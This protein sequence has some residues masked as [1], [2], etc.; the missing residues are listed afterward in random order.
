LREE[1]NLG[2]ASLVRLDGV[3]PGQTMRRLG[4]VLM[5]LYVHALT[6]RPWRY[7][8]FAIVATWLAFLTIYT[9]R[10]P[11]VALTG[12]NSAV[13]VN[14]YTL[15]WEWIDVGQSALFIEGNPWFQV[16]GGAGLSNGSL[17]DQNAAR[18]TPALVVSILGV[19]FRSAWLACLFATW[20]AWLLTW[21]VIDRLTTCVVGDEASSPSS[22]DLRTARAVSAILV[23]TSPGFLAFVGNIDI[24][25]FG[26]LSAPIGLLAMH[27]T[28]ARIGVIKSY[29]T[30]TPKQFTPRFGVLISL[31]L[32]LVDG[33][34]QLGIPLLASLILTMIA[35]R[36]WKS[37]RGQ[38]TAVS[39]IFGGYASL[40]AV[41]AVI[42][43][44][45]SGG[46]LSVH[47]E[48]R[49]RFLSALSNP[50][51]EWFQIVGQA[52]LTVQTI[53]DVYTPVHVIMGISGLL[54]CRKRG[55]SL[56]LIYILVIM[57]AVNF[58]RLHPRTMYLTFPGIYIG[59]ASWAVLLSRF[60][61]RWMPA[62]VN[63]GLAIMVGC[64][65]LIIDSMKF[66][67][68]NLQTSLIW[69][70]KT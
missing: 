2:S 11:W 58:T 21:Y 59:I 20:V 3:L 30:I 14:G 41:W 12:G 26:Y 13:T 7:T 4:G 28:L 1:S 5:G 24:H 40:L 34:M 16:R 8:T 57:L 36:P 47:N 54:V 50:P 65:P 61:N 9:S 60:A 33:V 32:F 27:E 46:S 51:L 42:A 43:R 69:W 35:A 53:F 19:F 37:L 45:G 63:V 49:T 68:N 64:L 25:Q 67:N 38:L 55:G 29:N 10:Q 22:A 23:C 18:M 39:Y 52:L 62:G 17:T 15:E 56:I 66:M 6:A 48:A 70:P 44:A 31:A